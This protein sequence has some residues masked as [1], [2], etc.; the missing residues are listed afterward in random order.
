VILITFL[1]LRATD[2]LRL[3]FRDRIAGVLLFRNALFSRSPAR[4][5]RCFFASYF[6]V[7]CHQVQLIHDPRAHLHHPVPMPPPFF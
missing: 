2:A 5:P 6:F 4:A 7:Q 3:L 1:K